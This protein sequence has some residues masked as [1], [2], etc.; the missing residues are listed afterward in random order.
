MRTLKDKKS[1]KAAKDRASP[2]LFFPEAI[3]DTRIRTD[4]VREYKIK[5]RGIPSGLIIV[6]IT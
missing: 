5:W 3:V 4:G 6:R 1:G 2:E